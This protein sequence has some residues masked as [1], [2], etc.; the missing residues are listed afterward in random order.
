MT[1]G[2]RCS[3]TCMAR[4]RHQVHR[5]AVQPQPVLRGFGAQ[6]ARQ[7]VGGL[8]QQELA[9]VVPHPAPVSARGSGAAVAAH[10]PTLRGHQQRHVCTHATG[11]RARAAPP[12]GDREGAGQLQQQ[13]HHQPLVLHVVPKA[14]AAPQVRRHG[15]LSSRR[16]SG[17]A[18]P[19]AASPGPLPRR[20]PLRAEV[21]AEA[22]ALPDVAAQRG[23]HVL[24]QLGAQRL[25]LGCSARGGGGCRQR[26]QRR[27][28]RVAHQQRRVAC[29]G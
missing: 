1:S 4:Q 19:G 24:Q 23:Q 15:S 9:V 10:A 6:P 7:A 2:P 26:R 29:R 13:P 8:D 12:G 17:V 18:P 21:Q 20:L 22:V 14:D 5:A 27:R 3:R 16:S 11:T 25:Q 28:W